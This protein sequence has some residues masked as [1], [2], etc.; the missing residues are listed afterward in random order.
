MWARLDMA[1]R[2]SWAIYKADGQWKNYDPERFRPPAGAATWTGPRGGRYWRRTGGTAAA[3]EEASP[4]TADEAFRQASGHGLDEFTEGLGRLEAQDV[5]E[6]AGGILQ[7]SRVS[8]LSDDG[9]RR[10][11]KDLAGRA[12]KRLFAFYRRSPEL[13][14]LLEKVTRDLETSAHGDRRS[15]VLAIDQAMSAAHDNGPVAELLYGGHAA[16]AD[17]AVSQ[18]ARWMLDWARDQGAADRTPEP[19]R[20]RGMFAAG[21]E[22]RAA[23][24]LEDLREAG[25]VDEALRELRGA[26]VRR[27]GL[28]AGELPAAVRRVAAGVARRMAEGDPE[29]GRLRGALGAA[30]RAELAATTQ[31]EAARLRG[32]SEEAEGRLAGLVNAYRTHGRASIAEALGIP[33]VW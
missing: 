7:Y 26:G 24:A 29:Y 10:L 2:V 5:R 11:A 20:A 30:E 9:V 27:E 6:M 3:G 19:R 28:V 4:A 32:R 21:W 14:A 25:G 17:E 33:D 23:R 31:G 12:R 22:D 18:A 16:G 13:N 1:E 8:D 15:Q